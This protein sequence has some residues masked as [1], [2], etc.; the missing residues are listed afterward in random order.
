MCGVVFFHFQD[1]YME[2]KH[3]TIYFKKVRKTSLSFWNTSVLYQCADAR[4]IHRKSHV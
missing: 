4:L 2:R 3:R 1:Y